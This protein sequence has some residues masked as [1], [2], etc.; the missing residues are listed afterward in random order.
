MLELAAFDFDGVLA[1]TEP[2]HKRA[3][4]IL[5]QRLGAVTPLNYEA[6]VGRPNRDFWL[7]LIAANHLEGVNIEEMEAR[8]Y[9]VIV[10]LTEEVGLRPT[11]GVETVLDYLAERGVRL[12]VC[13]SSVRS[14]LEK[15]LP[16]LGLGGRFEFLVGG[17]EVARKKPS[18]DVY[19][20][21]LELTSVP[22]EKALAVEDSAAGVAAA[23]AAAM[24]V[25]GFQNPGSGHQNL[26]E[27]HAVINRFDTLPR[28][29][30]LF[31]I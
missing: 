19:L 23:L 20:K 22:A 4:E 11:P 8:Q 6:Y 7:D 9:D 21:A 24:A 25:I 27:A 13:S 29:M 26:S 2:L 30:R 28:L 17:D 3:K 1:D 14:Y 31:V 12:T 18:P 5:S 16:L 10:E 15:M